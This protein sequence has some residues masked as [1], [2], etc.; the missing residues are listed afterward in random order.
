MRA[1]RGEAA[2]RAGMEQARERR[3]AIVKGEEGR[4]GEV[5]GGRDDVR[6][7]KTG[8]IQKI[9]RRKRGGRRG[10]GEARWLP[11]VPEVFPGGKTED[12]RGL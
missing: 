8:K 1:V 9:K 5:G 10:G 4:T 11:Q 6:G 7:E 3:A 2:R 12:N